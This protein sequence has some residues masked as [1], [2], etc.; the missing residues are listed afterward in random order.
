MFDPVRV[1]RSNKRL[2]AQDLKAIELIIMPVNIENCHWI[3]MFV[4]TEAAKGKIRVC[5]YDLE[6]SRESRCDVSNMGLARSGIR[7]SVAV[8]RLQ[9]CAIP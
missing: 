6:R 5:L 4:V 1:S 3:V 8:S 7:A 9:Q 2:P